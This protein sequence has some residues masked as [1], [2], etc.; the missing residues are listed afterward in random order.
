MSSIANAASSSPLLQ[1]AVR[2]PLLPANR[3][4]TG[5]SA[6]R[7]PQGSGAALPPPS[8]S[9]RSRGSSVAS[10]GQPPLPLPRYPPTMHPLSPRPRFS[11]DIL[12]HEEDQEHEDEH[13]S[14]RSKQSPRLSEGHVPPSWSLGLD[15]ASR[16]GGAAWAGGD[17]QQ[18]PSSEPPGPVLRSV[19]ADDPRKT[20]SAREA[21]ATGRSPPPAVPPRGGDAGGPSLGSRGVRRS[22]VAGTLSSSAAQPPPHVSSS[23]SATAPP[24]SSVPRVARVSTVGRGAGLRTASGFG[25]SARPRS[26]GVLTESHSPTSAAQ[27]HLQMLQQLPYAQPAMRPSAAGVHAVALAHSRA[28]AAATAVA[29]SGSAAA[30]DAHH[31]LLH[32]GGGGLGGDVAPLVEGPTQRSARQRRQST[33]SSGVVSTS[34]RRHRR[35]SDLRVQAD[36]PDGGPPGA[37]TGD[38]AVASAASSARVPGLEDAALYAGLVS[39]AAA[40]ASVAPPAST[41][42]V[43][44]V[45]RTQSLRR[46]TATPGSLPNM[47]AVVNAAMRQHR[48]SVISRDHSRSPANS[49]LRVGT[50]REHHGGSVRSTRGSARSFAFTAGGSPLAVS[51][52]MVSEKV[53]FPSAAEGSGSTPAGGRRVSTFSM[54][55][56]RAAAEE[57]HGSLLTAATGGG[58][59]SSADDDAQLSSSEPETAEVSAARWAS[60]SASAASASAAAAAAAAAAPTMH[61]VSSPMSSRLRPSLK[62]VAVAAM[63]GV[64]AGGRAYDGAGASPLPGSPSLAPLSSSPQRPL[65]QRVSFSLTPLDSADGAAA[66][67]SDTTRAVAATTSGDE[68]DSE[69]PPPSAAVRDVSSIASA[70]AAPLHPTSVVRRQSLLTKQGSES[71]LTDTSAKSPAEDRP[72]EVFLGG[73]CNP[74]TWRHSIAIPFFE[75]RGV[76]Y[77]NPQVSVSCFSFAVLVSR[78]TASPYS[79][80]TVCPGRQLV[81]RACRAGGQGKRRGRCRLLRRW[82]RDARD[83]VDD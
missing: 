64:R 75:L 70:A 61:S 4:G 51:P 71:Q 15:S 42:Q 35:R 59:A 18:W 57:A 26:P 3:S 44:A 40:Q 73:A 30:E 11:S 17:A 38:S 47:A 12:L 74:T 43:G 21:A 63:M 83:C 53:F 33:S 19:S 37:P 52:A 60:I 39:P 1:M 65:S 67:S 45:F 24:A 32:D 78:L 36:L 76:S 31:M 82:S 20:V 16:R 56:S 58:L 2:P 34:G 50:D 7:S 9:S 28:M 72:A 46:M 77:Y 69:P 48:A 25:F 13:S 10:E 14:G 54:S 5:G 68:A 80:H 27:L 55:S 79:P 23:L 41:A 66:E 62:A 81:S 49:F 22:S 8:S 29:T 6:V